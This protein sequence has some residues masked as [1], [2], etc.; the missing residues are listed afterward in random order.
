MFGTHTSMANITQFVKDRVNHLTR[1]SCYCLFSAGMQ[2]YHELNTTLAAA[3]HDTSELQ[4]AIKET[5]DSIA[6]LKAVRNVAVMRFREKG[7]LIT[8]VPVDKEED[9]LV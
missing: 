4:A 8:V 6:K 1:E 9:R 3:G 7:V 5:L 2:D